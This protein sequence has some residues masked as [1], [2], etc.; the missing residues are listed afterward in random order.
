MI[1]CRDSLSETIRR[2]LG[3][4]PHD[5]APEA[6]TSATASASASAS[7]DAVA[8]HAVWLE[9]VVGTA[10][11]NVNAGLRMRAVGNPLRVTYEVPT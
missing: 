6:S 8:E 5:G 4:I 3:G 9:L 11:N 10:I 2:R 7:G 1:A